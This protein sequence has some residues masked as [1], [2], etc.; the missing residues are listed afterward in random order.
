MPLSASVC[1]LHHMLSTRIL[2]IGGGIHGTFLARALTEDCGLDAG[3]VLVLDPVGRPV[4]EWRRRC[5][6]VGM[7]HLRSTSS[8]NMETD[9]RALRRWARQHGYEYDIHFREPYARPS[10]YAFHAHMDHVLVRSRIASRFVPGTAQSLSRTVTGWIVE[11]EAGQIH[12]ET[13]VLATG[14]GPPRVP[15]WAAETEI[16]H[17]YADPEPPRPDAGT[18]IAVI[19]GGISAWQFACRY[20]G[21]HDVSVFSTHGIRASMFDSDPGYLGPKKM[22]SFLEKPVPAREHELRT[23]RRPG[24]IPPDLETMVR[25]HLAREQLSFHVAAITSARETSSG[26]ELRTKDG[27][28]H[29]GFDEVVCATGFEGQHAPGGFIAQVARECDLP[30]STEGYPLLQRDLSW[31][32]RLHVAGGAAS[33]VLGPTAGNIV[34]AHKA[35]RTLRTGLS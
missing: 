6:I 9:Y 11:S 18:R 27:A 20:A 33:L 2:I 31:A 32:P 24:S 22:S 4:R 8:H 13:V 5:C 16:R 30:C 10:V 28:R 1:T 19:G 15:A 21:S 26:Y 17:V 25:T 7:S 23:A 14:P 34:G 3:D 29:G 12:A 35:F